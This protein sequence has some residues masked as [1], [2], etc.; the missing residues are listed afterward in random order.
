MSLW[1]RKIKRYSNCKEEHDINEN[2]LLVTNSSDLVDLYN[3]NIQIATFNKNIASEY[4][5][6]DIDYMNDL[7]AL[8]FIKD[9]AIYN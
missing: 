7:L 1:K 8:R 5:V 9:N 6:F 4:N 3:S 2:N